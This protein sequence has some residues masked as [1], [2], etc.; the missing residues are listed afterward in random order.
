[1]R[2]HR[3]L[4]PLSLPG[5]PG[6]VVGKAAWNHATAEAGVLL[7][8]QRRLRPS[9]FP[10]PAPVAAVGA[11][12]GLTLAESASRGLGVA[13][14]LATCGTGIPVLARARRH[15]GSLSSA[16]ARAS[17]IRPARHCDSLCKAPP[18]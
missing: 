5:V 11:D 12:L 1:M 13:S 3:W 4:C 16:A 15:A 7:P 9:S 8:G 10:D 17:I 6:G 18:P 14:S 2:F